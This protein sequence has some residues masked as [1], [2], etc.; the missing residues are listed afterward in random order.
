MRAIP[1][2]ALCALLCASCSADLEVQG[3]V[4]RLIGERVTVALLEGDDVFAGDVELIDARGTTLTTSGLLVAQED[5]R[6][7][8]FAIPPATAAGPAMAKLRKKGQE[9]S[10]NVPLTISRVAVSLSAKGDLGI[11]PLPPSSLEA[12]TDSA[13]QTGQDLAMAPAG[14]LLLSLASD[15]VTFWSLKKKL[16]SVQSLKLVNTRCIAAMPSGVAVGTSTSIQVFNFE[17]GT[18][19]AG[20]SVTIAETVALGVSRDGKRAIA[21]THC[22]TN[23]D[24]LPDSDCL[25][26]INLA[27]TPPTVVQTQVLDN[28]H[29][30]TLLA[31]RD[32]GTGALVADE[33]K[34][35]GVTFKTNPAKVSTITWAGAKPVGIAGRI[36]VI[37]GQANDLFA[38]AD[39]TSKKVR[40]LGFKGT[41]LQDVSEATLDVPPELIGFGRQ[42]DLYVVSGTKLLKVDTSR[43]PPVVTPLSQQLAA[44]PVAFVVQP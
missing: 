34:L 10:Y 21:L 9:A 12:T 33:G 8:S 44:P 6:T 43:E 7:V 2:A 22:D 40:M 23:S 19:T 37:E 1:T 20:P 38:V 13:G 42:T 18:V 17:Q 24:K 16:V 30:A 39:Q 5:D 29:G 27:A 25:V 14:D 36:T 26:D 4:Q 41:T 28:Q 32:D 15:N 35:Y 31:V 11:V 3:D